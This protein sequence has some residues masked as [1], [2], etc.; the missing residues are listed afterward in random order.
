MV[1]V[2]WSFVVWMYLQ[3]MTYSHLPPRTVLDR[4]TMPTRDACEAA[5]QGLEEYARAEEWKRFEAG[6]CEASE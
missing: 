2:T 1:V 5:R 6:P 4:I 3:P